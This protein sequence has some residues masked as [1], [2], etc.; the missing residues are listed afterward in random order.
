MAAPVES[1]EEKAVRAIVAELRKIERAEVKPSVIGVVGGAMF[2]GAVYF[3][4]RR[5]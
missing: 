5:R 3:L 2:F 4:W 1:P